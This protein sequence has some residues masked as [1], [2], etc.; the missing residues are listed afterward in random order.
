VRWDYNVV[1]PAGS[2][3]D[4]LVEVLRNPRNW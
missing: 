3:E 4:E 1:P 2:R